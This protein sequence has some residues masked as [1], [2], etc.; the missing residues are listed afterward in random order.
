MM[1]QP[2][3]LS[4]PTPS[5]LKIASASVESIHENNKFK[6]R[7]SYTTTF[8]VSIGSGIGGVL[9]TFKLSITILK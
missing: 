7:T 1:D 4:K 2:S 8:P 9:K 5:K 6:H 3:G